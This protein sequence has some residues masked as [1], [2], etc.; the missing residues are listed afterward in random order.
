MC[1]TSA[2]GK[3]F[4]FPLTLSGNIVLVTARFDDDNGPDSGSAYVFVRSGGV[5]T[6]QTKLL[7]SDGVAGDNMGYSASLSGGTALIGADWADDNGDKSGSAY[8]FALKETI[9]ADG[10]ESGDT[11]A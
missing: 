2:D 3:H 10:F 6:E 8:V 7:A 4:G 5:W 9:F 1:P 11:S